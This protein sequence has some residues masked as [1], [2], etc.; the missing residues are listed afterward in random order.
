MKRAILIALTLALFATLIVVTG[1][2]MAQRRTTTDE[3]SGDDVVAAERWEYLVVSGSSNS[4]LT[5]SGN[6]SMR[7][8]PSGGFGREAFVLEQN[9]DK[10]GA[11]GWELVSISGSPNDPVYYFKRK[12]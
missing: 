6:P 8:E 1:R 7:K 4:N 9:L 10:L 2:T 5:P 11:R 3:A 12:K